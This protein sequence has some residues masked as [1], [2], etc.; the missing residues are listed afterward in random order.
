MPRQRYQRGRV[1]LKGRRAKK[2]WGRYYVYVLD[3]NGSERR[4]W[5]LEPLG[6]ASEM[7][8]TDARRKLQDIIDRATAQPWAKPD[9]ETPWDHFIRTRYLPTRQPTWKPR[10]AHTTL[11]LFEH[12]IIPAFGARAL[13]SITVFEC[14]K[15]VHDK[16]ASGLSRSMVEVCRAHLRA[17]F[18]EAVRQKYL[19]DNPATG[20]LL[21]HMAKPAKRT[22]NVEECR[23]LAS[24]M[25]DPGDRLIFR[26]SLLCGLRP[27]ETFALRWDDV[28][29][30]DELRID[31]AVQ[32]TSTRLGTT[33]TEGSTAKVAVS[34][35]LAL[36]V[37][38]WR[39]IRNPRHEREFLFPGR[40]D[41]PRS[42]NTWLR[43][44]LQKV[45][46]GLGIPDVNFQVLRRTFSTRAQRHGT[47]KDIQTQ[48]RHANVQ[49]T[50]GV[51]QQPI[52]ESVRAMVEALDAELADELG[53]T[54]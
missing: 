8:K 53:P 5:K 33:K 19:A 38:N 17:V 1:F 44:V 3:E 35:L 23:R 52:P 15:F 11:S 27:G 41:R 31:E 48:M 4:K 18:Q 28:L 51:Y 46:T 45:A 39:L 54:N 10:T 42:Y 24:A 16:A 40:R 22:L 29:E 26:I 34:P 6:L 50:L 47:P 32:G 20:L 49:T 25:V 7:T 36:E 9:P 43:D 12:H 14:Q 2:W 30:G 13:D 21:A 37:A